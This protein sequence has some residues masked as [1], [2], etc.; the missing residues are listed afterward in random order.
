MAKALQ[1]L[2]GSSTKKQI[3]Q[4]FVE[5]A[6]KTK[7]VYL[8]EVDPHKVEQHLV[9]GFTTTNTH[10]DTDHCVGQFLHHDYVL[11][12]RYDKARR[13]LIAEVDL[14]LLNPLHHFFVV[15]N[16]VAED[17]F[18]LLLA[19]H[20]HHRY[21]PLSPNDGFAPQFKHRYSILSRPE[22][23]HPTLTLLQGELA[24]C[25]AELKQPFILEVSG[26]SLFVYDLSGAKPT[27]RS[28]DTQLRFA[29]TLA[30]LLERPQ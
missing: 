12:H 1:S 23:F 6:K 17:M 16:D 27:V 20:L 14:H 11:L 25:L 13:Y 28:L 4:A 30:T 2:F 24:R 15:P 10:R 5:Y 9:R 26:T 18:T 7:A 3:K 8:G 21:I 22:Y 29:C 19:A